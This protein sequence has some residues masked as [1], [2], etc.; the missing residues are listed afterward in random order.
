MDSPIVNESPKLN[1]QPR[2]FHH[3]AITAFPFPNVSLECKIRHSHACVQASIRKFLGS[4]PEINCHRSVDNL[5]A[6]RVLDLIDLEV[7]QIRSYFPKNPHSENFLPTV[8]DLTVN[9][10][11]KS[12]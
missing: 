4:F 3:L 12:F 8:I 1:H 11:E 6:V 5:D 10:S 7:P 9:A 2:P